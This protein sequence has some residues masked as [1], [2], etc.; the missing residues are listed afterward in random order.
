MFDLL[1]RVLCGHR[2]WPGFCRSDL[3]FSAWVF[4]LMAGKELSVSRCGGGE[5]GGVIQAQ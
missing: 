3:F 1:S 5:S 2:D 4:L